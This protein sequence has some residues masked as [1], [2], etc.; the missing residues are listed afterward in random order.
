MEDVVAPVLLRHTLG[1]QHT[2]LGTEANL[3]PDI[4]QT[5][6][7]TDLSDTGMWS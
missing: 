4:F 1:Q 5:R 7:R 3:N 2:E 6:D